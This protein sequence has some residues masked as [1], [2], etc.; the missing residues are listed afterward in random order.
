MP[1][2]AERM[3]ALFAG[4]ASAHGTHGE[5]VQDGLKWA[6]KTTARTVREPVTKQLWEKHLRGEISLGVIPIREDGTCSWGSIDVDQYGEDFLKLIDKAERGKT[7]PSDHVPVWC[8]LDV[9]A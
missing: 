6:I 3:M 8:E 5:P 2:T 4:F 9:A 1:T 7:E